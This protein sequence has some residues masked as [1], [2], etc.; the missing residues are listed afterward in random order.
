MSASALTLYPY[1]Q[2][3]L[4]SRAQF[5]IGMFARQTGK[6]FTSSLGI[7][8]DA[9]DAEAA[10]RTSKWVILSR[11]E[12]QAR[13]VMVEGIQRH[14]RAYAVAFKATEYDWGADGNGPKCKALEATLPGGSR[15]IALPANPD[16][17]RG[18]SANVY[19]DEFAFHQDSRAI[20]RSV[21]PIVSA[22]WKC[23][24]TSTPNGKGN[25]FYDLMTGQDDGWERHVCDIHRAVAEGLPRDIAALRAAIGDEDAWAQE[26][27]LKWLDEASAW[28][29][30]DL[31][32]AAENPTAGKP[33][34]TGSGQTFIGVDIGLRGDLWVAWVLEKVGDV[35]WTREVRTLRRA[36]FAEH[37]ATLDELIHRWRPL[38]VAMDQTGLGE[39]PVEDARRRYGSRV[40]G[41]LF[42]QTTKHALATVIRDAF[43]DRRVRIPIG[44]PELRRDLHKVQR[45]TSATGAPRFVAERDG[46]GHAD[47]F[48]ALA[49]ALS[50]ASTTRVDLGVLELSGET[51][52]SSLVALGVPSGRLSL[53][54]F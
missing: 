41:V 22:G 14:L 30:F 9:L 50:A 51:R 23:W 6:T 52:A 13:E 46:A 11:G 36:T 7:V 54:G 27:E 16:T 34:L 40:E 12:R 20:W 17:A 32:S 15:I 47:R 33:E 43:E 28:L 39:K 45:V 44:D 42:T 35:L 1:Q 26:Y 31:I 29:P 18:F 3:W 8:N 53:E 49:L 37:D 38:R 19:L 21:F 4:R 25:K 10:S 48:W 2:A 5:K 24:V